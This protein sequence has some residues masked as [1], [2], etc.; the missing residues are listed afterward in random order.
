MVH[1]LSVHLLLRR[2]PSPKTHRRLPM[3]V[4]LFA[5]AFAWELAPLRHRKASR[6]EHEGL[7]I[8]RNW[9]VPL[10]SGCPPQTSGRTDKLRQAMPFQI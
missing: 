2:L 8:S 4:S 5:D 1:S 9:K 10:G 6:S 7:L 3:P